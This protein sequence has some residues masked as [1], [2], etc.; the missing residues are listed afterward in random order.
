MALSWGKNLD[1][2][3]ASYR[4][5]VLPVGVW[6]ELVKEMTKAKRPARQMRD[7]ND[8]P[9]WIYR[10]CIGALLAVAIFFVK[11]L[12]SDLGRVRDDT[13]GIKVEVGSIR[14]DVE[15]VEKKQDQQTEKFERFERDYRRDQKSFDEKLD[16]KQ[17][18]K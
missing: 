10:L 2:L 8:I 11:D 15:R 12:P 13:I 7:P 4:W 14:K 6:G 18:R 5:D 3:A 16:R 1:A 17:D 9:T